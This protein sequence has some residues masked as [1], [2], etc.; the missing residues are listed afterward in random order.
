MSRNRITSRDRI[1]FTT[2]IAWTIPEQIA[3]VGRLLLAVCWTFAW[4]ALRWARR[5]EFAYSLSL[6]RTMAFAWGARESPKPMRCESCG[7]AGPLRW[8]K[9][10]YSS[11]MDESEPVTE[12][13][14]VRAR[15]HSAG[16]R[17]EG[18]ALVI[19]TTA[20]L[21]RDMRSFDRWKQQHPGMAAGAVPICTCIDAA[22]HAGRSFTCV[23]FHEAP[24]MSWAQV[25]AIWERVTRQGGP[26]W[27][28]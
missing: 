7:W 13:P 15:Q 14:P 12:C 16:V 19:Q 3:N 26:E 6:G 21:T 8:A 28:V 2:P 23:V 9:H 22:A 24:E 27:C 25:E 5:P 10:V 11:W 17:A 4:G 1:I 20:V 18:V